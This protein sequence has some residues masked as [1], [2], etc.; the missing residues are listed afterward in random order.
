MI[1]VILIET[2]RIKGKDIQIWRI[3]FGTLFNEL[4]GLNAG[5]VILLKWPNLVSP[6]QGYVEIHQ[7]SL[8]MKD[9]F[10]IGLQFIF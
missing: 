6:T 2:D 5:L 7:S 1:N 8:G 10:N 4:S 3:W 9:K